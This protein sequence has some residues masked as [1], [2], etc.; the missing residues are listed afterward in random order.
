M[1]K[2][3]I[4]GRY[5]FDNIVLVRGPWLDV[6]EGMT[7]ELQT[8]IAT[9][10]F[11]TAIQT[12]AVKAQAEPKFFEEHYENPVIDGEVGTFYGIY[13]FDRIEDRNLF[14]EQLKINDYCQEDAPENE[15]LY[16]VE[17]ESISGPYLEDMNRKV[18]EQESKVADFNRKWMEEHKDVLGSVV[19][20]MGSVVEAKT[21]SGKGF[22]SSDE[23]LIHR[24]MSLILDKPKF[25]GAAVYGDGMYAGF[26]FANDVMADEF[27]RKLTQQIKKQKGSTLEFV[28]DGDVYS[29]LVIKVVQQSEKEK[30]I[31]DI[32]KDQAERQEKD[33]SEEE[34]DFS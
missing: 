5:G 8:R 9:K 18:S 10:A 34:Q 21:G 24:A 4:T 27:R 1:S 30:M 31:A 32:K 11:E 7:G 33:E 2:E 19:V 29:D 15:R 3:Q 22:N 16:I 20:I 17:D 14:L 26:R 23:A 28:S 13:F 25:Y 6:I 12:S